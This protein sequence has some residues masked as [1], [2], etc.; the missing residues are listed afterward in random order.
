MFKR[1]S[2][3][4][5]YPWLLRALCSELVDGG[6]VFCRMQSQLTQQPKAAG[7]LG[8]DSRMTLRI[9]RVAL[10]EHAWFYKMHVSLAS[11][12]ALVLARGYIGS[13]NLDST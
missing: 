1:G 6:N 9:A 2:N 12:L 11:R 7:I 8:L 3:I 5:E 4:G 13:L 10:K